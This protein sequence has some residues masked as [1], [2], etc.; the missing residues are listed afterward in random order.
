M[1]L[2]TPTSITT[3][4]AAFSL[5]KRSRVIYPPFL[6]SI[7]VVFSSVLVLEKVLEILEDRHYGVRHGS[8]VVE[9]Q[10]RLAR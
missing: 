7:R 6:I 3:P 8:K 4:E 2:I 10:S 9:L 5:A 1:L